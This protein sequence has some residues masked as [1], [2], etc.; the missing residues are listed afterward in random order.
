MIKDFFG[1]ESQA[2][3]LVMFGQNR[4]S[5]LATWTLKSPYILLTEIFF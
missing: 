4:I 2:F 3:S 5:L 1:R